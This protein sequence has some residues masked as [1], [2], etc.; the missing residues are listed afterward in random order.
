M[1]LE[2]HFI[3]RRQVRLSSLHKPSTASQRFLSDHNYVQHLIPFL[4]RRTLLRL[5]R[6]H[7]I[8]TPIVLPKIWCSLDGIEE[9][10]RVLPLGAVT[11]R[12]TAP[13]IRVVS[14]SFGG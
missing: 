14:R 9:L 5:A 13:G 10:L 6:V 3:R 4:S 8:L 7:P 2:V 11:V 12:H 1:I